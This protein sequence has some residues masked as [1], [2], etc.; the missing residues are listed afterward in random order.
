MVNFI[1]VWLSM[2]GDEASASDTQFQKCL[3]LVFFGNVAL[4]DFFSVISR[5]YWAVVWVERA[6]KIGSNLPRPGH[7]SVDLFVTFLKKQQSK[8]EEKEGIRI[9]EDDHTLSVCLSLIDSMYL[10]IAVGFIPFVVTVLTFSQAG[11]PFKLHFQYWIIG[12]NSSYNKN[13]E[14]QQH[15][16]DK[17]NGKGKPLKLPPPRGLVT[18]PQTRKLING[19]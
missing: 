12:F 5:L 13:I 3:M 4:R 2:V 17:D 18:M 11:Q 8:R 14:M 1:S 19:R 10:S 7:H 6:L 9:L 16:H 15:I